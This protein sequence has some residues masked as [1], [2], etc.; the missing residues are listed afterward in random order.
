MSTH[1]LR[2]PNGEA[3]QYQI[4]R[5]ARRTIG[6]KVS[7]DGL[8]VHAP[9]RL[10]INTLETLVQSK[11]S[12]IQRKWLNRA[13]NKM[14][15]MVWQHG[16]QLL[17]QGEAL[18]LNMITGPLR[19]PA[20]LNGHQLNI[21]IPAAHQTSAEL[22]AL[23]QK[24]AMQWY[25]QAGLE[26][27]ARRI[28]IGAAKLG[29]KT[30][31]IKLSNARSRWGSCSSRGEIRLSWRLIQAKPALIN[32]VVA[33]E[34]AHLKEMNHSAR[35]WAIVASLYPDYPVAEQELK[36]LSHLLHRI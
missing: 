4:I 33:H 32:Y 6:L 18:T 28:A 11:S 16:E 7:E 10:P 30:P 9:M 36:A 8:V 13:P 21:P 2:L 17:F 3:I 14:P 29:V 25:F 27:Y 23:L 19:S 26:D 24:K 12:W 22:P 15:P 1:T 20:Q 35:F 5:R 31:S 34:L